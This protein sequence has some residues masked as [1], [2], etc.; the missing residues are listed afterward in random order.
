M[1]PLAP[2]LESAP[3]LLLRFM[4]VIVALAV[5]WVMRGVV[6]W[7]F[8][9]PMRR[10][11]ELT[12]S[13]WDNILL[14][15]LNAP[16]RYLVLTVALYLILRLL[17]PITGPFA[18]HLLRTMVILT[19]FI[20]L[21]RAV[22]VM[23][24]SRSR[25]F[26]MTGLTIEDR[27]VPFVR[28]AL[29][30]IL[31]AM[32]LVIIVQEWGYDVSGLVAG[33][34]LGGL[35]FSL[36]AQDTVANLFGFTAIVGDTPFLVG[37]FIKTPDLEGTVEHVG[38]RST[39]IRRPDQALVTMP[40]SKLAA[41][42][43]LNWSRLSK[44]WIDFKLV[45]PYETR[46]GDVRVLIE[47]IR[48][49]LA[50]REKVQQDSVV[51]YLT[52][53]APNGLEILIRCYILLADWAAFSDEREAINLAIL[54]LLEEMGLKPASSIISVKLEASPTISKDHPLDS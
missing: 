6:L 34:G 36:A 2:F 35:A 44:R 9:R 27:L 45:I 11:A 51:V 12:E 14:D 47:R 19:I 42:P 46:S 21:Y 23:T 7:L 32:V 49:L 40:N 17:L 10:R 15:I 3:E 54:E 26:R 50:E 31:I 24:F 38:L 53:F 8:V 48:A 39:R 4:L 29:R 33:L 43:I 5:L 28:T 1:N 52:E 18:D 37:E 25:L 20:G 30:L 13:Q 22:A 16:T 41:S